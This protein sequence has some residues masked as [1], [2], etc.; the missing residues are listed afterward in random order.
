MDQTIQ[1]W[2]NAGLIAHPYSEIDFNHRLV[3]AW[4]AAGR[5]RY[6]RSTRRDQVSLEMFQFL[7]HPTLVDIAED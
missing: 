4:N 1:S 3:Q 2:V 5:P 7:A 6:I